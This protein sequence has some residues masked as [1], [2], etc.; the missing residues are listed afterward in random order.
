MSWTDRRTSAGTPAWAEQQHAPSPGLVVY[1]LTAW[2]PVIDAEGNTYALTMTQTDHRHADGLW[3]RGPV[4]IAL[5]RPDGVTVMIDAAAANLL[6]A[7][8][9]GLPADAGLLL[10]E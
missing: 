7:Y 3:F 4:R 10:E 2:P 9:G 8:L 6:R 5:S 1:S